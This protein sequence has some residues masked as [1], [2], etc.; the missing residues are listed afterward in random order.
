MYLNLFPIYFHY[1]R[2]DSVLH[3]NICKMVGQP[4]PM[5]TTRQR[6]PVRTSRQPASV[7][8]SREPARIEKVR[9]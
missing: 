7:R 2:A 9:A 8:T 5:R 3:R 6:A 1:G 4:A